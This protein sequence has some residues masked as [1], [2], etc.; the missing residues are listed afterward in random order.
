MSEMYVCRK[1][2]KYKV[3]YFSR[4]KAFFVV[5]YKCRKLYRL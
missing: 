2:R 3:K 4:A 1:H 5:V